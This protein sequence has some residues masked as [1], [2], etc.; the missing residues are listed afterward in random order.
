MITS[1][2]KISDYLSQYHDVTVLSDIKNPGV[3]KAGVFWINEHNLESYDVLVLNRGIGDGYPQIR[4]KHRILWTHDLPHNGF[5][6]DPRNIRPFHVVFMSKYAE[7]IWRTFYKDIQKSTII[8]NGVD[9]EL[10]KNYGYERDQLIFASAPNRGLKRLPLIYEAINT[11]TPIK[12]K[13]FSNLK[14]LHPNE[15]AH[16]EKE[17]IKDS[18]E[19]DYKSCE[20]VGIQ[21]HKPISQRRLAQQLA[22]SKLMIMPTDYPEICS[23]II[24]QSLACGTP[25]ITTG[26]LGSSQEWVN[27]KN[28]RLT[29]YLPHDYMVY[30]IETVRNAVDVLEN[31][32][33]HKKLVKGALK[34]KILDWNQVGAKW[35]KLINRLY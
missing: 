32:K 25:I 23:N 9:K 34:T 27:R 2:F 3:T 28:G 21:V 13:A 15:A 4:A 12:M 35:N 1:L 11:R 30:Q 26:N 19:L 18:F 5:I 20:E 29:T 8:P 22:M 7:R 24:L 6:P 33:L 17:N 16:Q 31:D 14:V 10:F